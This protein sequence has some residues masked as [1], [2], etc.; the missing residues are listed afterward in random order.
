MVKQLQ[1]K[2]IL[3]NISTIS[4]QLLAKNYREGSHLLK[5]MMAN[6][7][8]IK[9]AFIMHN[10]FSTNNALMSVTENIQSLMI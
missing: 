4:S 5:R 8:I 1:I 9:I 3:S 7:S 2:N 10:L 6:L